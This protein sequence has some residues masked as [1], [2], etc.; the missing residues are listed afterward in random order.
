MN[1]LSISLALQNPPPTAGIPSPSSAS[2]IDAAKTWAKKALAVDRALQGKQERTAECDEACAVT[3]VN[4]GDF[5]EMEGDL[6][7][8]RRWYGEGMELSKR[9]GLKE[10]VKRGREGLRKLDKRQ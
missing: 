4:L 2:Q 8:A 3:M 6:Q 1:N 5:A 9:V 7:E 10:G